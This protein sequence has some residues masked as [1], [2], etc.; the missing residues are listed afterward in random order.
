MLDLLDL[1]I[2]HG[3]L[4]KILVFAHHTDVIREIAEGLA[5]FGVVTITGATLPK[6]RQV[7]VDRFQTD[8]SVQ[9]IVCN[10]IAGGVGVTLTAACKVELAEMSFVPGDNSQAV[11]RAHRIGQE[12]PV[13]V[14][15]HSLAGTPDEMIVDALRLK[16]SMIREVLQ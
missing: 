15:C 5:E 7:A 12:R 4:R 10:I 3:S 6:A 9:V 14:R 13:R 16:S 11:K 8:P 2:N 1:E